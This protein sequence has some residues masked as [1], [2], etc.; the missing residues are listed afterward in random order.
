MESAQLVS[1]GLESQNYE[2]PIRSH[3]QV[4]NIFDH[5]VKY[6]Y[7][8]SNKRLLILGSHND[9]YYGAHVRNIL[10]E[11]CDISAP[12][13]ELP[14]A[15]RVRMEDFEE[16]LVC[17]NK[18]LVK[19]VL[20]PWGEQLK[21]PATYLDDLISKYHWIF[22]YCETLSSVFSLR[23][24]VRGLMGQPVEETRAQQ[25]DAWSAVRRDLLARAKD[26][27]NLLIHG[28]GCG[29]LPFILRDC[30]KSVRVYESDPIYQNNARVAQ[31][32][33]KF[34]VYEEPQ[35]ETDL[36][37][38]TDEDCVIFCE[39]F[40]RCDEPAQIASMMRRAGSFYLT[41]FLSC[42]TKP[43]QP[44][45]FRE[46][47]GQSIA[48]GREDRRDRRCYGATQRLWLPREN[49]LEDLLGG[50]FRSVYQSNEHFGRPEEYASRL[51]ALAFHR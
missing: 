44:A 16:I 40:N 3:F 32:L 31:Y 46:I 35:F 29:L 26:T 49:A 18:A 11:E 9:S 34:S 2:I 28:S 5:I 10:R 47:G 12:L 48:F 45:I 15:S 38:V 1:F 6:H 14:L 30:A 20:R 22:Q 21:I 13:V 51:V 37:R 36:R 42:P 23:D 43:L 24:I 50:E 39:L 17:Y 33:G 19:P 4:A 25:F 41:S 8:G 27:R 7:Y